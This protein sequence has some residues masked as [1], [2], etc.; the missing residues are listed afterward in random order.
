MYIWARYGVLAM[1]TVAGTAR[2]NAPTNNTPAYYS[3]AP[4][5][6]NAPLLSGKQLTGPFFSHPYQVTAYKMA[7]AVE[8]ALFAQPCYCRCDVAMRHKSL[9]SCFEG[10]HGAVCAT[11]MRQAVYTYQ[12]TRLGRTPAQIRAGIMRG[13]WQNVDVEHAAL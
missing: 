12:Q 8:K 5:S 11:C 10:T 7:A 13:E 1:V 4:R 6:G 3:V 9:H 2:W